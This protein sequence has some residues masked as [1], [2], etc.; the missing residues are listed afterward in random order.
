MKHVQRYKKYISL[1]LVMTL[2]YMNLST[3][4]NDSRNKIRPLTYK[5]TIETE[6]TRLQVIGFLEVSASRVKYRCLSTM[7]LFKIWILL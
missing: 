1:K 6:L 4:S 2:G 5:L 3:K 7:S